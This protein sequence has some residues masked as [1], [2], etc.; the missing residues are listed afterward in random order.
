ML[1]I[2]NRM[3]KDCGE[4]PSI[5]RKAV[6]Y[7]AYA[8]NAYG[9][10]LIYVVENGGRVLLYHG[11]VGWTPKEVHDNDGFPRPP[12][13]LSQDEQLWLANVWVMSAGARADGK[14]A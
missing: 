13:L 14:A 8:E 10:Q 7:L 2:Q 12:V 6:R 11:D 9:E 4:P 5:D 1:T 3:C